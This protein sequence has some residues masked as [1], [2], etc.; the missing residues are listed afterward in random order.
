ME[1]GGIT[2][3]IVAGM[4]PDELTRLKEL[5]DG[6]YSKWCPEQAAQAI[7]LLNKRHEVLGSALA[8]LEAQIPSDRH[9]DE[10]AAQRH[11]VDHAKHIR[12]DKELTALRLRQYEASLKHGHNHAEVA[13]IKAT[14]ADHIRKWMDRP[15]FK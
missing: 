3:L 15:Y 10:Y 7:P 12:Y 6:L 4:K 14:T 11:L 8:T 2:E 5:E 1:E 9:S 13:A